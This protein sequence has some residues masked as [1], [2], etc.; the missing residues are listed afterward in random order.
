MVPLYTLFFIA[1]FAGS[2]IWQKTHKKHNLDQ[3]KGAVIA[4]KIIGAA[5]VVG[6]IVTPY[7]VFNSLWPGFFAGFFSGQALALTGITIALIAVALGAV[8][9]INKHKGAN[10]A[11]SALGYLAL[12][13]IS[14]C[15]GF[16]MSPI[17]SSYNALG[18]AYNAA[19]VVTILAWWGFSLVTHKVEQ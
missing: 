8:L 11:F 5:L 14:A 1:C 13:L 12:I 15:P 17:D 3:S 9:M 18:Q 6:S 4:R 7:K 16:I 10:F 2:Y 19:L